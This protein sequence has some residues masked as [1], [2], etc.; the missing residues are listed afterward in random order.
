[1][2]SR[3][4]ELI[5]CVINDV[6]LNSSVFWDTIYVWQMEAAGSSV[7]VAVMAEVVFTATSLTEAIHAK[8]PLKPHILPSWV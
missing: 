2:A 5:T 7:V 4:P 8:L 6:R 3:S 1:V